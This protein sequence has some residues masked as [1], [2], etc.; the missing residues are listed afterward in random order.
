MAVTQ[1]IM[2]LSEK[3]FRLHDPQTPLY[4]DNFIPAK[5]PGSNGLILPMGK[6]G[7][8]DFVA[9]HIS[10]ICSIVYIYMIYTHI[11]MH[12]CYFTYLLYCINMYIYISLLEIRIMLILPLVKEGKCITYLYSIW[13]LGTC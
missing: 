1:L 9:L 10:I 3:F 8:G 5:G 2:G 6:V 12:Y 7:L 13:I 11:I 4:Q